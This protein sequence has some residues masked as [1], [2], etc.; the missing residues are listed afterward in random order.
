MLKFGRVTE[1]NPDFCIPPL[2]YSHPKVK[3]SYLLLSDK[4][5]TK[6]KTRKRTIQ[7]YIIPVKEEKSLVAERGDSANMP[8]L[9][10]FAAK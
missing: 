9:V 1:F 5:E 3:I 6:F 2:Y 10:V 8:L 7:K 4:T